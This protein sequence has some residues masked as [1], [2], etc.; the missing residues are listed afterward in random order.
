MV[1]DFPDS[2]WELLGDD[3]EALVYQYLVLAY[4]TDRMDDPVPSLLARLGRECGALEADRNAHSVAL[5]TTK[6]HHAEEMAAVRHQH[7]EETAD[8]RGRLQETQLA[9]WK[10]RDRLIHAEEHHFHTRNHAG[11]L[12]RIISAIEG[13]NATLRARAAA[14][15]EAQKALEDVLLSRWWRAGSPWRRLR[16]SLR[17]GSSL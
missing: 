2:V 8:L 1:L 5:R 4:P 7:D 11:N 9:I 12:E 14:G 16:S 3:P 6:E 10:E 17:R 15:D 13:D